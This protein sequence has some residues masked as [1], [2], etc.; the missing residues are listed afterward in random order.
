MTTTT[1]KLWLEANNAKTAFWTE[2]ADNWTPEVDA[3][4]SQLLR[5]SE[6]LFYAYRAEATGQSVDEV[7]YEVNNKIHSARD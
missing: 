7:A 6:N 3:V 5:K 2:N 4:Y 1:Y